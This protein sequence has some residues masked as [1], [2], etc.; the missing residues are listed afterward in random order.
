MTLA[1]GGS[2]FQSLFFLKAAEGWLVL[3]KQ[4]RLLTASQ[5]SLVFDFGIRVCGFGNKS[6]T[7]D[8]FYI[9]MF[10]DH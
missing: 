6:V 2:L 5:R 8:D 10:C 3:R 9:N 7:G 4:G 1:S